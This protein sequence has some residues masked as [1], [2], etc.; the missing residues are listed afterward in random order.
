MPTTNAI[1][2]S[3]PYALFQA[4]Y[5][6]TTGAVTGD[7]TAYTIDFDAA[8]FDEDSNI[9]A[10]TFTVAQDGQYQLGTNLRLGGLAAGH[11]SCLIQ[12]G[13]PGLYTDSGI[14]NI[15]AIRTPA[16]E[17]S[18]EAHNILSLSAGDV[19]NVILTVSGGAKTVTIISNGAG[20]PDSWFYGF[21]I[22]GI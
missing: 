18:I 19:V 3:K 17:C 21:L 14:I 20:Q 1:N 4:Y 10:G 11:T 9:A 15:G 22:N 8:Q 2:Q 5:S 13:K 12:I 7:G 6:V 16:N